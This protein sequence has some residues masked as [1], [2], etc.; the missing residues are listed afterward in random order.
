MYGYS[1]PAEGSSECGD[2]PSSS[3]NCWEILEYVAIFWDIA[4]CNLYIPEDGNILNI[5][6]LKSYIIL[7]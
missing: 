6:K 1:R 3:I 7:D 2:E 4:P 5:E